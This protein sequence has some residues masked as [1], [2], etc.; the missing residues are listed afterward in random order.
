M[1]NNLH[2]TFRFTR[3]TIVTGF[4]CSV[5]IPL[6]IYTFCYVEDVSYSFLFKRELIIMKLIF[7]LYI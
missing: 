6:G 1:R 4:I 5:A 7:F 2:Q 3:A